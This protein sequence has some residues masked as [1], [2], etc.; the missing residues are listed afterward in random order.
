MWNQFFLQNAHFALNI[1][2]ALVFFAVF[3]L[4][5]DAWNRKNK[6]DILRFSGFLLLSASFI[7][8]ASTLESALLPSALTVTRFQAYGSLIFRLIS[9]LLLIT[10]LFSEPLQP[11]PKAKQSLQTLV[12][13]PFILAGIPA[14][15]LSLSY[16]LMAGLIGFLYL[17]RATIGLEDH[18]KKVS[19]AF[20]ILSLHEFFNLSILLRDTQNIDLYNLV[21]PFAPVWIT[22]HF[23]LLIAII[24]IAGW[25]FYYLLKR[26]E[27]QLFMIL[28]VCIVLIFLITAVSFT[29]L[30]LHNIQTETL[31]TLTTDSK[32]LQ[33]T[34]ESKKQEAV[35]DAQM[36]AANADIIEALTTE[37]KKNLLD[38][39]QNIL[40]TKKQ[41]SLVIVNQNGEVVARGEDRT[42]IGDSL[43]SDPL[44]IKA[45]GG[46]TISTITTQEGVIAP[47]VIV[48]SYVPITFDQ[49]IIG[50][51]ATGTVVDTTFVD[52]LKNATGLESSV[53]GDDTVSATTFLSADG[54]SR[55]LGIKETNAII[56]DTVLSHGNNFTGSIVLLGTP[57]FA[58]YL[59][60]KDVDNTPVGML[61]VGKPQSST[62]TTAGKSIEMTF[63]V[64]II[65]LSASIIP[66]KFISD[67]ITGQIR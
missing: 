26:L 22:G 40:I 24:I 41:T 3:W 18:L 30:L 45:L 29:A 42:K 65:L 52:G 9:Y 2:A 19:L 64:I 7:L 33:F 10:S 8:H 12:L 44:F 43:S 14:D 57:Y 16:P 23:L 39:A 53:Y 6:R 47:Q 25:V 51:V 46:N 17:R 56:R 15:I 58:S 31:N 67:Y 32:V 36:I 66:A 4:Y 55:N 38:N 21:A 59:P 35:S 34:L 13:I 11:K 48:R 62:L 61:M 28:N 60:L 50:V 63:I 27:T 37:S 20:F 5:F 54:A 49:K 1:F